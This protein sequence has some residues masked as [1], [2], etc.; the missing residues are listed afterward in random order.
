MTADLHW[1][2]VCSPPCRPY[3]KGIEIPIG[4]IWKNAIGENNSRYIVRHVGENYVII[5]SE[6]ATSSMSI[7][8]F[9]N[10]FE[11][12]MESD[13][14]RT[15]NIS[16]QM[17]I[18]ENA[19]LV[20]KHILEVCA[21]QGYDYEDF[22]KCG[23]FESHYEDIIKA[24]Y[25]DYK[26]AKA[27]CVVEWKPTPQKTNPDLYQ[28]NARDLD[29][30]Y[31]IGEIEIPIGSIWKLRGVN[32]DSRSSVISV[33]GDLVYYVKVGCP[34]DSLSSDSLVIFSMFFERVE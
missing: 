17:E 25:E 31:Y 12:D 2:E 3:R 16:F 18:A 15:D 20:K 29:G 26:I 24:L 22:F 19:T 4:S 32:K 10:S 9:A 5:E 7:A 1:Y 34:Y 30:R 8:M 11:R 14:N 21:N 6:Y 28:Y 33:Q 23:E 13:K 27:T